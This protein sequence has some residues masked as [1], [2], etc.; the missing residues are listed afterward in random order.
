MNCARKGLRFNV[1]WLNR[2]K[3]DHKENNLLRD[4][5]HREG[6]EAE[7]LL[8]VKE[9]KPRGKGGENREDFRMAQKKK[10]TRNCLILLA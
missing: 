6:E 10:Q 8:D 9:G 7:I 3:I 5:K 4:P 1:L 2:I